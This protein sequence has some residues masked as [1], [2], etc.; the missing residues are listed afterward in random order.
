MDYAK[1]I[2]QIGGSCKKIKK[3]LEKIKTD[4]GMKA[5]EH[6]SAKREG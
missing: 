2:N 1:G 4:K 3:A 6:R 5:K